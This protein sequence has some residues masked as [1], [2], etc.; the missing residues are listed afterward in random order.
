MQKAFAFGPKRKN[1]RHPNWAP[2]TGNWAL[3]YGF[4]V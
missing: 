4:C 1:A 3:I 2:G